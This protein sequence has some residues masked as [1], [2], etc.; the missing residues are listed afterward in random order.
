MP[1]LDYCLTNTLD[2]TTDCI[3]SCR[4][5]WFDLHQS[6]SRRVWAATQSLCR[7]VAAIKPSRSAI[8][9]NIWRIMRTS[10]WWALLVSIQMLTRIHLARFCFRLSRLQCHLPAV[11]FHISPIAHVDDVKLGLGHTLR[12]KACTEQARGE[13]AILHQLKPF[14]LECKTRLSA[15]ESAHE[16]WIRNLNFNKS[17]VRL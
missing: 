5:A 9:F 14:L 17:N 16:H 3:Q 7:G 1:I 12:A 13:S 6:S 10:K 2:D 11:F 8:A 15:V 4:Y